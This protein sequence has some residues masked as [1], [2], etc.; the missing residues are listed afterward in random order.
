[1]SFILDALKK[2]EAERQ[3]KDAPGFASV[4]NASER[5]SPYKWIL[6]VV[7]LLG[8]NLAALVAVLYMANRGSDLSEPQIPAAAT[9]QSGTSFSEIVAEAKRT[10]PDRDTSDSQISNDDGRRPGGSPDSSQSAP[11][12]STSISESLA[13]FSDLRAQNLLQL[14]DLHLD[15]HV[16]SGQPADRF[17]FINMV[18]YKESA[19]LGEGPVVKQITPEGVVL[20]FQGTD[21]LLPRE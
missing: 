21:F 17:V 19:K 13:T 4:P 16:Y 18:K 12:S 7:V 9:D 15:I 5:K 14:P 3:K 8:V 20:G 6:L 11:V 1:M 2:S 10:Q